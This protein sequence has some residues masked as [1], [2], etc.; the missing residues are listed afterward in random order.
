M[1]QSPFCTINDPLHQAILMMG[2]GDIELERDL[3]MFLEFIGLE[4]LPRLQKSVCATHKIGAVVHGHLLGSA[5]SSQELFKGQ[6]E[7]CECLVHSGLQ[8]VCT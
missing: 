2:K 7:G 6:Q 8:D 4:L 3:I 5:S 1:Q